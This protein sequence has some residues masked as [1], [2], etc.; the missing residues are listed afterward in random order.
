MGF[1]WTLRLAIGRNM[2]TAKMK[3]HLRHYFLLLPLLACGCQSFK[4]ESTQ[5]AK[6][7]P[8]WRP[9]NVVVVTIDTLRADRLGCY[10]YSKIETPNLD[11]LAK[12]G[13]LF[14]NA[15]AQTPLTPPSHA[16]IFTGTYPTVHHVR[17]TGGFILDASHQTLAEILQPR[18]WQT[19]AFVGSAVLNRV[20]GLSQGFQIY[21]DRI[22]EAEPYS[23]TRGHPDRRAGEVVDLAIDWLQQQSGQAPFFLWVHVYDPHAPFDPPSPFKE[24]Y[25]ARPYDGEIAYTDRELGRLFDFVERKFPGEKTVM[26]VL[27]DHGESLGEHGEYS[28]GVFLY[29]CTL[30]IPW[31]MVGPG[32]PKGQRIKDQVRTIDLLPTLM[33]MLGGDT[34]SACQGVS[35]VPSFSGQRIST[36]YSYAETLFPKINMGWA[37]LRGIRSSKWKYIRAPRSELYD[38]ENDP[39][40]TSNLIQR[41]P[42]DAEK[43]EYQ[44]RDLTSTGDGKPAEEVRLNN[45]NTETEE[46]LRSLGYVS[47]GTPRKLELTGQ[48]I[49]PKDRL[50]IL[51]LVEES[52]STQKKMPPAQRIH[53]L[54]QAI[55]RDPTNPSLYVILGDGLEKH[56]R[57]AEALQL[58]QSALHQ[59]STATNKIYARMARVYGRQGNITAAISAFRKAVE[60]DPTDL[61]T[62]NKLAVTYLLAGRTAEAESALK[63]VLVLSEQNAQAHNSLGWIALKKGDT[64]AAKNHFERALQ[65]DPDLMEAYINLGMLYKQ[66]GDYSRARTN[67]ETFLAKASPHKQ[68]ESIPRIKSELA[69]VIQKQQ[70]THP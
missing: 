66:A 57:Y 33:T 42:A 59:E 9:L 48:G 32:I 8:V 53:L 62:Q 22:P 3:K 63:A 21:D 27:A 56:Q 40:E 19:A 50:D 47:G 44:L 12:K 1:S 17:D 16:S 46:Q 29:D 68:K 34:P 10:G 54:Q 23:A 51:A 35:L 49:D 41:Y 70:K 55:R 37:E 25:L 31:I 58:Y 13:V 4:K 65:L 24:K 64:A 15:V 14:E 39:G 43:L 6:T 18:G 60:L 26:A 28:H 45:L 7:T 52:T 30:R 11:G 38:L 67:F 20:F 69:E 5:T 2:S 61:E 36:T